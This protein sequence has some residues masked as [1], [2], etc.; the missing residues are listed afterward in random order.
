M[1]KGIRLKKSIGGE[2]VQP[3]GELV[4]SER[5]K[6][7]LIRGVCKSLKSLKVRKWSYYTLFG[8]VYMVGH[9]RGLVGA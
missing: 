4:V 5:R 8:V 7:L 3:M 1:R 9:G 6:M 2:I